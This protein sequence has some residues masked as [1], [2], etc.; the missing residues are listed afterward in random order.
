MSQS[1]PAQAVEGVTSGAGTRNV[2]KPPLCVTECVT[3]RLY[4]NYIVEGADVEGADVA[5][6]VTECVTNRLYRNN[7]VEGAGRGGRAVWGW[8]LY[9]V[10]LQIHKIFVHLPPPRLRFGNL[11]NVTQMPI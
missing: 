6:C 5:L 2:R 11:C 8:L 10:R 4:R 7:A 3:N 9:C 1:H